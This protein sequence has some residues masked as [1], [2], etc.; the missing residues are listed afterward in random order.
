MNKNMILY[1]II[2]ENLCQFC[3]I[4]QSYVARAIKLSNPLSDA[5]RNEKIRQTAQLWALRYF[6]FLMLHSNEIL[7]DL[8]I[9]KFLSPDYTH[10]NI[11]KVVL[12]LAQKAIEY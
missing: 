1:S 7:R 12:G 8:E 11:F 6:T 3:F 4:A 10:Q 2:I 9:S 5:H